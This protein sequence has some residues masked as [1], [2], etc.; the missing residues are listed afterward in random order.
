MAG[1]R[2]GLATSR[3]ASTPTWA[4]GKAARQRS[5]TT[6]IETSPLL[7]A[8]V[9]KR[10]EHD[11]APRRAFAPRFGHERRGVVPERQPIGGD[12]A[13]GVHIEHVAEVAALGID[14]PLMG[15]AGAAQ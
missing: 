3:R 9:A 4:P 2:S 1:W 7:R 13:R 5:E 14:Q 15:D 10:A 6:N 8:G 11:P 12:S